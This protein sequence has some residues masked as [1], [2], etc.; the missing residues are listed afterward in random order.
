VNEDEIE[1]LVR[2]KLAEVAPELEGEAI[3]ADASFRDQFDLD[4][5]DFLNFIIA[6]HEAL[7]IEIPERDYPRLYTLRGWIDYLSRRPA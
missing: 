2:A 1:A 6:M 4:S 7:G 3:D 5:M